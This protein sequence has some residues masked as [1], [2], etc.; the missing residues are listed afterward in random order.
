MRRTVYTLFVVFWSFV[1]TIAALHAMDKVKLDTC[2]DEL[3]VYTLA[4]VARHETMNDCWMAIDGNVYDFTAYID[5]HPTPPTVLVPWCGRDAAEGMRTKGYGRD[6]SARA[7]AMM[8]DYLIGT[9]A[10]D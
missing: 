2:E 3:P 7:W 8:N 10:R 1:A 9:L 6:H 4:E 5:E